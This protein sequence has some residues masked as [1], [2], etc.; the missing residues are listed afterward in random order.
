MLKDLEITKKFKEIVKEETQDYDLRDFLHDQ[1][2]Y[3]QTAFTYY[4]ETTELYDDYDE[5]CEKWLDSLV[6][7]TGMNPWELFPMWDYAVNS[8]FNK[9]TVVISM[10]EEFCDHLLEGSEQEK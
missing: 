4:S 8:K 5:D 6:D 10:F 1:C 2:Q 3:G 7:Q 9:W